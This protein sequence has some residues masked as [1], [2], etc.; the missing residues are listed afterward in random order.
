MRIFVRTAVT[1]AVSGAVVLGSTGLAQAEPVDG[2][3][4]SEATADDVVDAI[5]EGVSLSESAASALTALIEEPVETIGNLAIDDGGVSAFLPDESTS[6]VELPLDSESVAI[7]IEGAAVTSS[8]GGVSLLESGTD[9]F[10]VHPTE[11]GVQIVN[12]ASRAVDHHS[13]ALDVSVPAGA[14]WVPRADGGLDLMSASNNALAEVK[15][16]WSF[17]STGRMLPTRFEVDG[18]RIVQHVD[19]SQAVFPVVSDPSVSVWT[20]AK[21]V[22]SIALLVGGSV[23][24]LASMALKIKRIAETTKGFANAYRGVVGSSKFTAG[25][26]KYLFSM[27]KKYAEGKLSRTDSAKVG[28]LIAQG[29]AAILA[30]A[31]LEDCGRWW[32]I[33]K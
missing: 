3:V 8:D 10:T 21:C 14:V 26:M 28:A 23:V 16:P 30:V 29:G 15:A 17:D 22:G 5:L 7:E 9:K 13:F 20:K 33:V 24:K 19:T 18:D 12:V 6:R 32:G 11:M 27:F 31:G 25:E 2:V 4:L 1:L